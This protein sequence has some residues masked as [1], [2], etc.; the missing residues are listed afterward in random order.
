LLV[1]KAAC[2]SHRSCDCNCASE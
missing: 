2:K 1:V